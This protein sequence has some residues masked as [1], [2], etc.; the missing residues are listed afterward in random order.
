MSVGLPDTF[1]SRTCR[2]LTT[3]INRLRR[4]HDRARRMPGQRLPVEDH[5]HVHKP[6]ARCEHVPARGETGPN[7]EEQRDC[8]AEAGENKGALCGD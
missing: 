3:S 2:F 6:Q 8:E 5:G 1:R 4:D 7:G